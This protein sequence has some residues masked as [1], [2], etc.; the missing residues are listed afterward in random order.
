MPREQLYAPPLLKQ[1]KRGKN[2]GFWI[3]LIFS[4]IF[5]VLLIAEIRLL[6]FQYELID[7]TTGDITPSTIIGYT[8]LILFFVVLPLT[9]ITA[10]ILKKKPHQILEAQAKFTQKQEQ[11]RTK[12]AKE[13]AI[14]A[15]DQ[16]EHHHTGILGAAAYGNLAWC[17]G[18]YLLLPERELAQHGLIIGSSGSGKTVTLLR[19]VYLA[20]KLY[21]YKIFFID[22]KPSKKTATRFQ[23]LLQQL[24][25]QTAIW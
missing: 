20:T 10:T 11:K 13:L 2:I 12:Q 21:N 5:V 4:I 9:I 6:F 25:I 19:I 22:A 8:T 7:P 18:P 14:N 16:T 24:D 1:P 23:A 3:G 17:N 15:P